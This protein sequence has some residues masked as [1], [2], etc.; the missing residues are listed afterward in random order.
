MKRGHGAPLRHRRIAAPPDEP[1]AR[2]RRQRRHD[3]A[4]APGLEVERAREQARGR[5][6]AARDLARRLVLEHAL[7]RHLDVERRLSV[8]VAR[9]GEPASRRRA[10]RAR[11]PR[12]SRPPRAACRARPRA[13]R[14]RGGRRRRPRAGRA[15]AAQRRRLERHAREHRRP[16]AASSP[17]SAA[18]R[19]RHAAWRRQRAAPEP[20]RRREGD[21][22]I[23]RA[24]VSG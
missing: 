17:P 14:R 16:P 21:R 22:T 11:R 2:R 12:R 6:V 20:E 19:Q 23:T 24:H 8:G 18:R 9:P 5:A 3:G 13:P 1:L 10:P 4:K 7:G 15:A